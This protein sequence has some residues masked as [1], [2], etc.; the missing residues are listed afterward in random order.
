M[1]VIVLWV[2]LPFCK[3]GG[4]EKV[5]EKQHFFWSHQ[6]IAKAKCQK[7]LGEIIGELEN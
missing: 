6:N 4:R 3:G 7:N 5:V 1:Q 2:F